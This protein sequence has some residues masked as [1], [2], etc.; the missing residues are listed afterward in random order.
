MRTGQVIVISAAV[1]AGVFAIGYFT[2]FGGQPTAPAADPND[3]VLSVPGM[4]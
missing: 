4:H 2:D 1:L 3:Y